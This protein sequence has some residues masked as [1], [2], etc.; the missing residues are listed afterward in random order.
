MKLLIQLLALLVVLFLAVRWL[1]ENLAS[2]TSGWLDV[3]Y[4]VLVAVVG[5]AALLA[6][7]RKLL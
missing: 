7:A 5:V 4:Y 6:L 1:A 2:Q 3:G